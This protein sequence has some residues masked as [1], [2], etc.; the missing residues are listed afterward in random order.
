[1]KIPLSVA[2]NV[3]R[4]TVLLLALF[5]TQTLPAQVQTPSTAPNATTT[6]KVVLGPM[7]PEEQMPDGLARR[8]AVE[9][10][11]WVENFRPSDAIKLKTTGQIDFSWEELTA[12]YPQQARII[13]D[14]EEKQRLRIVEGHKR[15][16]KPIPDRVAVHHTPDT[17]TIERDPQ[18][19]RTPSGVSQYFATG[20]YRLHITTTNGI[21]HIYLTISQRIPSKS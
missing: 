7:V 21:H 6:D 18:V 2:R 4:K 1:M 5:S 3:V 16:S 8:T 15:D 13:D 17:V 11:T 12:S 19:K 20:A 14:Y 10:R 9:M